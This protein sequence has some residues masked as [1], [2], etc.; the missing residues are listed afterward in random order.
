MSDFQKHWFDRDSI[1]GGVLGELSWNCRHTAL[2]VLGSMTGWVVML[3][4]SRTG[5]PKCSG[6]GFEVKK[7]QL[8]TR[9]CGFWRLGVLAFLMQLKQSTQLWARIVFL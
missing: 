5:R 6:S 1:E 7:I 2:I 9:R 8:G 3:L 4:L